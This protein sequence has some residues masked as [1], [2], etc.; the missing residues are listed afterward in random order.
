MVW[1]LALEEGLMDDISSRVQR[2][3]EVGDFFTR[4]TREVGP[5]SAFPANKR[6]DGLD[7]F[8]GGNSTC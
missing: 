2:Q 7:D 8:P 5:A 6:C 1:V 4:A 3:R